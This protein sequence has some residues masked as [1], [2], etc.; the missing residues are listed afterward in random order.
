MMQINLQKEIVHAK[1]FK[2]TQDNSIN[3]MTLT[4]DITNIRVSYWEIRQP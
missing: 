4:V 2:S 1:N 3:Q